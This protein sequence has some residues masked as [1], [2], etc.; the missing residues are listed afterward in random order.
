MWDLR[1]N[2][3]LRNMVNAVR[4]HLSEQQ[5]LRD[6][7][8]AASGADG[9]T[10]VGLFEEPEK[11]VCSDHQERLRLFCETDQ[12]LVCLICRDG[13]NHQGHKFKP[14]EEAAEPRKVSE[15]GLKRHKL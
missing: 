8:G 11:L 4:E 7:N 12:K 9:G 14:V 5:A 10:A 3:V 2:R 15:L 13:E 1:S 6:M